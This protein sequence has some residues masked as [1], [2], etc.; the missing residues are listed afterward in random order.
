MCYNYILNSAHDGQ[1]SNQLVQNSWNGTSRH[2]ALRSSGICGK[3]RGFSL[4][5]LMISIVVLTILMGALMQFMSMMQQRYTRESRV[6]GLNQAG[7]SALDLLALD[8]GQAGAYPVVNSKTK[9]P[10]AGSATPQVVP[11]DSTDGIYEGAVALLDVGNNQEVAEVAAVAGTTITV[12]VLLA[13]P[14]DVWVRDSGVPYPQGIMFSATDAALT[15]TTSRL[16]IVGDQRGVGATDR[17]RYVEYLFTASPA[18]CQGTL[19]RS[20]SSALAAKPEQAVTVAENL[21]NDPA[22]AVPTPVFSYPNTA[23]VGAF[24]YVI[25]V[26]V[27]LLLRTQQPVE[28]PGGGPRTVELRQSFVPRNLLYSLRVAQDGSQNLSPKI[29]CATYQ[30]ATGGAP[31]P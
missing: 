8:I 12:P 4:I 11:L 30:L 23:T 22:A 1:S 21:C 13:H 5:E 29:P 20:D 25:Q 3:G 28:G 15:S 18:N 31:C 27:N 17:L 6:A 24:T 9:A 14:N 2:V 7:K 26:D 16:R 10:I 19:T